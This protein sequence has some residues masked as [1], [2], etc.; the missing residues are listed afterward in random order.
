MNKKKTKMI[1][2]L[3]QKSNNGTIT[4][5]NNKNLYNFLILGEPVKEPIELIKKDS[6][7]DNF[8]HPESTNFINS[9]NNE[10][11]SRT[12]SSDIRINK[13]K[14]FIFYQMPFKNGL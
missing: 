7:L 11:D 3:C 2:L 1:S 10:M 5:T 14:N 9:E 4:S 12:D 13:V 8:F 6:S